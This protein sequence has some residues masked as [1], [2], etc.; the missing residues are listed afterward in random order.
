MTGVR[1]YKETEVAQ[2]EDQL[3]ACQRENSMLR[4]RYETPYYSS[5][6]LNGYKWRITYRHIRGA[7][8]RDVSYWYCRDGVDV[9]TLL[10]ASAG[11]GVEIHN[12]EWSRYGWQGKG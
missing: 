6:P 7:W 9:D 11:V 10:Q 4:Q 8:D 3:A 1:G 2:L 5:S 12:V